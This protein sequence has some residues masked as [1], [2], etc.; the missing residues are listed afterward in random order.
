MVQN[1]ATAPCKYYD[2]Q[3]REFEQYSGP[4]RGFG[5]VAYEHHSKYNDG[6]I[7]KLKQ[8]SGPRRGFGQDA[9]DSKSDSKSDH[10]RGHPPTIASGSNQQRHASHSNQQHHPNLV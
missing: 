9:Y 4:H 8:Y 5:Q 7:Q 2:G 10:W 1:H 3:I 6:R